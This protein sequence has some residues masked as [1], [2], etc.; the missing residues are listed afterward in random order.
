MKWV[1]CRMAD[2]CDLLQK[3]LL[4]VQG[5]GQIF[6]DALADN[7]FARGSEAAGHIGRK[8]CMERPTPHYKKNF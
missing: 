1:G 2:L 8:G 4:A 7:F 5:V 3:K 6:A